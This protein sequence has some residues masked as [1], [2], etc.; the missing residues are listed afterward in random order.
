[1]E[2]H[3]FLISLRIT[4]GCF[5]SHFPPFLLRYYEWVFITKCMVFIFYIWYDSIKHGWPAWATGSKDWRNWWHSWV[6][7]GFVAS[8]CCTNAHWLCHLMGEPSQGIEWLYIFIFCLLAV[9]GTP[10]CAGS[11]LWNDCLNWTNSLVMWI[12]SVKYWLKL[13]QNCLA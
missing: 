8:L 4:Y 9:K 12:H 10:T 13:T 11:P 5:L 6:G 1:M 3:S 7:A 2:M